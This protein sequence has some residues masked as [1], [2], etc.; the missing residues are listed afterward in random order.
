M[1]KIMI[2]KLALLYTLLSVSAICRAGDWYTTLNLSILNHSK[3]NIKIKTANGLV[4]LAPGECKSLSYKDL[5]IS[6]DGYVM[7]WWTFGNGYEWF[8]F[9][10]GEKENTVSIARS[11][12]D[13]QQ[14]FSFFSLLDPIEILIEG[15]GV[16]YVT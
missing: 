4:K 9:A 11:L 12:N 10:K 7:W 16:A 8:Y 3:Q 2:K 14:P 6:S 1:E 13:L 5:F 15:P